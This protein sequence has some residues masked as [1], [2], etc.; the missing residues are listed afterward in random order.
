[1]QAKYASIVGKLGE[2]LALMSKA[3]SVVS[4]K[5]LQHDTFHFRHIHIDG[6]PFVSGSDD[7]LA[8]GSHGRLYHGFPL[9]AMTKIL[10]VGICRCYTSW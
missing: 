7:K 9:Q 2:K 6:A 3:L 5:Q 8:R 4:Q 1:M 10:L